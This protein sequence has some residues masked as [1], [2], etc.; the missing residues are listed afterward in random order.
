MSC[1]KEHAIINHMNLLMFAILPITL[2]GL[3]GIGL[4][5]IERLQSSWSKMLAIPLGFS[6]FLGIQ[7]FFIYFFVIW[8]ISTKGYFL[9]LSILLIAGIVIALRSFFSFG[10]KITRLDF[11]LIALTLLYVSLMVFIIANRT[12]GKNTFDTVHYLSMITEGANNAHFGWIDYGTGWPS[13]SVNVQYDF[14]SFYAFGSYLAFMTDG[15]IRLINPDYLSITTHVAIWTLTIIYIIS[16]LGLVLTIIDILKRKYTN[17]GYF[18]VILVLGFF[19]NLYFNNVYAFYGNTH[20]TLM[21]GIMML[22][23]FKTLSNREHS[24]KMP[25]IMM[26]LSSAL[27]ATSSSGFFIGA[28]LV[29]ILSLIMFK[30]GK[31]QKPLIIAIGIIFLPTLL[32][33]FFYLWLLNLFTLLH[34]IFLIGLFIFLLLLEQFVFK[35]VDQKWVFYFLFSVSLLT[36]YFLSWH[37]KTQI[38]PDFFADHRYYDMVWN[39]LNFTEFKAGFINVSILLG[40]VYVMIKNKTIRFFLLITFIL[41]LNPISSIF[42]AR[43]MA[44]VVYYRYFDLIFNP[45]LY[46]I[47]AYGLE[48]NIKNMWLKW[49]MLTMVTFI[50]ILQMFNYYHPSFIPSV[51]FNPIFRI[52]GEQVPILSELKTRIEL[53]DYDK[54]VVV[55]QIEEVRSFVPN[56]ITPISNEIIRNLDKDQAV[57]EISQLLNIFVVRDF[58][59]QKVFNQSPVYDMTCQLLI[60]NRIDFIIVD[61]TQFYYSDNMEFIPLEFRV[62]DCATEI[63]SNDRYALYQMYWN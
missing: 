55:S 60:D 38:G 10:S 23:F 11:K 30:E 6:V 49:S 25:L 21:V 62:R 58:T 61:R 22:I 51:K 31:M 46:V 2:L 24:L 50:A 34:L 4:F 20:R 56:I 27:I 16:L 42:V 7:Q 32:F 57:D 47:F 13:S 3:Y 43:Y 63:L 48:L 59:G 8:K 12:L 18:A 9:L 17:Q 54:A 29:S 5:T 26:L 53:E 45:Y 39:H 14:Q 36:V 35:S 44:S 1:V 40:L 33:A 28:M 19:A 37:Q 52:E 41:F 15:W